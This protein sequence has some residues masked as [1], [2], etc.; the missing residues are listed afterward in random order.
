MISVPEGGQ[1]SNWVLGTYDR[2]AELVPDSG[3]LSTRL[4]SL[5]GGPNLR[6]LYA[7]FLDT[8]GRP[9]VGADIYIFSW[10]WG[11]EE[12]FDAFIE[13]PPGGWE[14]Y[15]NGTTDEGGL[16]IRPEPLGSGNYIVRA[17]KGELNGTTFF[18]FSGSPVLGPLE[19]G[20]DGILAFA[21]LLFAPLIIPV[22]ALV[23]SY[24]SVARER[25]EGSLDM[26]LSKPV[27]RLGVAFGKLTGVFA[28]MALPV[29]VIFV[30]AAGLVWGLTGQA[31]TGTF[32]AGLLGA[33]LFLLLIYNLLFLAI[34]ANVRNLGTALLVS[35]LAFLVFSFFWSTISFMA[36]SLLASPGSVGWYEVNVWLSLVSPSGL[37]Q[38]LLSLSVPGFL[39]GFFGFIGGTTQAISPYWIALV[40]ALWLAVPL[41]L[42]F[43]AMKYRVTEG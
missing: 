23:V 42:F 15:W 5:G 18:G 20:P 19:Y 39:G 41:G 35:I 40:A 29:V 4:V 43:L 6:T 9:L 31:P 32:L 3:L 8:R 14:P 30:A 21:A 26:L 24:D 22:M 38:H 34:S 17:E 7:L 37:Y 11:E 1:L 27:S 36:A 12:P 33:V 10:P 25:S 28:S 2:G 13:G 16:Y